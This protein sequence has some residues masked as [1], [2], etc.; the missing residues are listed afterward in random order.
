MARRQRLIRSPTFKVRIIFTFTL[1]T[2]IVVTAMSL[3]SY[4]SVKRIYTNQLYD[5]TRQLTWLAGS[6]MSSKFLQLLPGSDQKSL[7]SD[8]Y[9]GYLLDQVKAMSIRNAFIFDSDLR[10]LV[11]SDTTISPGSPDPELLLSRKEIE[12]IGIQ[13]SALST[14]FKGRDGQWY[15]WGFYRIDDGHWL[16]LQES[17]ARLV[18]IEDL[19]RIFWLIGFVGV[20]LTAVVGWVL[21]RSIATPI[22]RLVSYSQ[23]LGKGRFDIKPPE[24]IRGELALLADAMDRMRQD[25]ARKHKDKEEMLAQIAHEIRNPLGGIELL[26][27]LIEEDSS[28]A[29]E[30]KKYSKRILEEIAGLKTLITEFLR[31]SRPM[32]AKPELVDVKKLLDEIRLLL[33]KEVTEKEFMIESNGSLPEVWFDPQHLR[34][35]LINLISNSLEEGD[36]EGK[37][38]IESRRKNQQ[39]YLIIS[40]DGPGVSD[41]DIMDIFEPFFTRRNNGTGLGLA[42]CRKLCRENRAEISVQ[43]NSKKGCTFTITMKDFS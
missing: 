38:N 41:S 35:I 27:G 36:N 18:K 5:Q 13:E 33:Q 2:A 26:A 3:V 34:Q 32:E 20:V 11:H 30:S 42:V 23:E 37:V 22:D 40:D 1:I 16:G 24:Q 43:N 31:Y 14:P 8:Y 29:D 7:T 6:Q 10:I 17:A 21:A 25:I 4:Y 12:D 39:I 15:L 19:A 28:T 9:R